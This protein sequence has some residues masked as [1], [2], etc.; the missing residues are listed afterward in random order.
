[1]GTIVTLRE[2]VVMFFARRVCMERLQGKDCFRPSV[3]Q[4][5]PHILARELQGLQEVVKIIS[6]FGKI[7]IVKV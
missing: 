4:I 2:V 3:C 1:V 6:I 5:R 7:G